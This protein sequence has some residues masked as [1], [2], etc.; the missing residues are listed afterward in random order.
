MSADGRDWRAMLSCSQAPSTFTAEKRV[1]LGVTLHPFSTPQIHIIPSLAVSKSTLLLFA[2]AQ[3]KVLSWNSALAD[4]LDQKN[5]GKLSKLFDKLIGKLLSTLKLNLSHH[6]LYFFAV[7]ASRDF[8]STELSTHAILNTTVAHSVPTANSWS[9]N[10]WKW[11][12]CLTREYWNHI[13]GTKPHVLSLICSLLFP[14]E[15]TL[16]NL[17]LY[18]ELHANLIISAV[19]GPSSQSATGIGDFS[20]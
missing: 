19:F 7:S 16:K 10:G 12:N 8:R 15:E 1:Q 2:L 18:Q 3:L 9:F 14:T 11:H 4:T 5:I 17:V 6:E 13:Q 20:T